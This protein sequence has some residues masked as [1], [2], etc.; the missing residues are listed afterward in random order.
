M[1][2]MEHRYGLLKPSTSPWAALV[3]LAKKKDGK[4]HLCV[5]YNCFKEVTESSAYGIPDARSE[6]NN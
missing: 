4:C 2:D 1:R 6:Q 5:D 3:V